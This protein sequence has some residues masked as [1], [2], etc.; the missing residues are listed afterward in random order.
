M[1]VPDIPGGH[2]KCGATKRQGEGDCQRPAGWGTDHVGVG[3][4]KLHGGK[5]RSHLVAAAQGMAEIAL[6]RLGVPIVDADPSEQLLEMVRESAGNVAC[7]R[8]LVGELELEVSGLRYD[9]DSGKLVE[10]TDTPGIAGRTYHQSGIPTGEAKAHV[11]VAMYD[12]ERDRLVRFSKAAIDCGL[13]ER[14]VRVQE[15]TAEVV[16][17]VM[18]ALLDDPELGLDRTQREVGRRIAGRHLRALGTGAAA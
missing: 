12:A 9:I 3:R 5:T 14:V 1:T 15:Q 16:A 2:D 4:C 8:D 6:K 10:V 11:L 18:M 7:L 13:A 17:K